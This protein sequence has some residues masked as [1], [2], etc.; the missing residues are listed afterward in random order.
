[1]KLLQCY[2]PNSITKLNSND[3]MQSLRAIHI[4]IPFTFITIVRAKIHRGNLMVRIIRYVCT[5]KKKAF[6]DCNETNH[7]FRF[8]F[9]K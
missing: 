3:R 6:R 5:I 9:H 1:M 7:V 4:V 2:S 8:Q